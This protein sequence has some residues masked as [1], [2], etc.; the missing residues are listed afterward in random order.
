VHGGATRESAN[1]IAAVVDSAK[2][3][4]TL[5]MDTFI[6]T[7]EVLDECHI[8]NTNIKVPDFPVFQ[9]L[10]ENDELISATGVLATRVPDYLEKDELRQMQGAAIPT[11]IPVVSV[12]EWVGR[13][14]GWNKHNRKAYQKRIDD[15]KARMTEDIERR[16]EYFANPTRYQNGWIKR[17]LRIDKILRAFNPGIGVDD[18]L[19]KMDLNACPAVD[20]FWKVREKR[21][22]STN[23]LKSG[24]VGDYN[25]L[26]GVTYADIIL[27]DSNLREF[28]RQADKTLESKVFHNAIDAA[29]ALDSLECLQ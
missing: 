27:T 14:F 13:T 26:S 2:L 28:I 23:R 4:Y 29:Q 10:T 8:Q 7:R 12:R 6:Y 15:F 24:D 22:R 25:F 11:R 1:Q 17:D 5:E 19:A 9:K 20:L 18:V 21:M 3:K 16:D